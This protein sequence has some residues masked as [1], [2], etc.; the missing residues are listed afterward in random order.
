MS[1]RDPYAEE[2]HSGKESGSP[3]KQ[4]WSPAFKRVSL[5]H[6]LWQRNP[7]GR[8]FQRQVHLGAGAW[9]SVSYCL[10]ICRQRL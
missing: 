4:A 3:R 1:I 7:T 8:A 10:W 2:L 5:A 9:T 6:S